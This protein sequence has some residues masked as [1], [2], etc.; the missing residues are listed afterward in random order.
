MGTRPIWAGK[1]S[2]YL[3]QVL[4]DVGDVGVANF[5]FAR[6]SSVNVIERKIVRNT[7]YSV[8]SPASNLQG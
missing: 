1:P 4:F 3:V 8:N 7:R 2:A 5:N 6:S